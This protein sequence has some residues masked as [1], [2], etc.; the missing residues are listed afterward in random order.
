MITKTK[1]FLQ[2]NFLLS[3][4]SSALIINLIIELLARDEISTLFKHIFLTPLF[5]LLN[6]VLISATLSLSNFFKKKMFVIFVISA[7]WLALGIAN[8][9][10]LSYRITPFSAIDLSIMEFD[11]SFMKSYVNVPL[12]LVI[13]LSVAGIILGLCFAY[14]RCKTTAVNIKTSLITSFILF[15]I[16]ALLYTSF[17][18]FG[19]TEEKISDMGSSYLEYGFV[20]CFTR[21]VFER[22]IE[23][24]E[25]Y[26]QELMGGILDELEDEESES[27]TPNI[28]IIQLE[29]FFDPNLLNDTVFSENPIP[30]FT[31]LSENYSSGQL[32]VSVLGAGTANTEFEILTGMSLD[33]FG[34]GE[35]PYKSVLTDNT[36]ESIAYNLK[37]LGYTTFAMHNNTAMF[38]DRYLVYPNLG[39]DSF[40]SSEFM[41]N[42]STTLEGWI[43]DE[44]LTEEIKTCLNSTTGNDF[45]FAVSVQGHG[46]YP[47]EE[48]EGLQIQITSSPFEEG[49]ENQ[50]EYYV[51]QLYEMD[52]FVGELI[53]YLE[54]IDEPTVLALYGDHMPSLNLEASD[55]STN[56][57]YQTQYVFWANYDM[58][59]LDQDLTT[60]Q[61][62]AELLEQIGIDNGTLTKIHQELSDDENYL[63]ILE[64][65]QYDM[66]YGDEYSL[67]GII[68]ESTDMS[69]GVNDIQIETIISAGDIYIV[70]KNLTEFS[71]VF[72]NGE[73]VETTF[74]NS[75]KLKIESSDI[76]K[77]D[78]VE[79]RI[80]SYNNTELYSS[81][82]Y[83]YE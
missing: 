35:F 81:N 9:V 26:S 44:C 24:P 74:I 10:V 37:E 77:G 8:Y 12:V 13:V 18:Y 59:E 7:F 36:S 57:N 61:F 17:A 34:T 82:V 49:L 79:I 51:N 45:V 80:L 1:K 50:V 14:K 69:F 32:E 30:I 48:I 52:L 6:V 11:W 22:G 38:Y 25:N 54:S 41:T 83:I 71:H 5:F 47:E 65:V 28:I 4:A 31:E 16:S 3:I 63:E 53:A 33:F 2:E 67:E 58:A 56:D 73:K 21:T 42:T 66:L 70:S 23:E 55:L 68:Y 76:S 29:S 46:S 15:S 72:V 43:K 27:I 64:A 20:S 40:V 60:Y 78:E 75:N 39:F 19:L 62:S